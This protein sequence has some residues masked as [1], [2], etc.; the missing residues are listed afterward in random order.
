VKRQRKVLAKQAGTHGERR[1]VFNE[2]TS[3]PYDK[4]RPAFAGRFL[5]F[6]VWTPKNSAKQG[7]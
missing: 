4:K 3:I 5:F 2:R 6:K 1:A 7:T